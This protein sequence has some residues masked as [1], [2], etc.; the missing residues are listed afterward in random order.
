[1]FSW[2][3][4]RVHL[5]DLTRLF[6]LTLRKENFLYNHYCVC[7][8]IFYTPADF[9]FNTIVIPPKKYNVLT[10]VF[11]W[12]IVRVHI[13]DLTQLFLLTSRKETFCCGHVFY[14]P[15]DFTFKTIIMTPGKH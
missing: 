11:S 1:M 3:I 7:E 15:A 6:L 10:V 4:V 14:T 8:H 13:K 12:I 5:E 2:I 9:T